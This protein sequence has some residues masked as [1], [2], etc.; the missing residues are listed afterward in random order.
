MSGRGMQYSNSLCD[1]V[2]VMRDNLV[3]VVPCCGMW[4]FLMSIF[5]GAILRAGTRMVRG[6]GVCQLSRYSSMIW[7]NSVHQACSGQEWYACMHEASYIKSQSESI[8][9][10]LSPVFCWEDATVV[11]ISSWQK[12][13]RGRPTCTRFDSQM[14]DCDYHFASRRVEPGK[15]GDVPK[16]L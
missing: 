14:C 5:I 9:M 13:T 1:E 8:I 2:N 4:D 16:A 11:C 15:Q 6:F 7:Y 10:P 3:N 12:Q